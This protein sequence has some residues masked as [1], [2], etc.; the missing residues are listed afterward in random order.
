TERARRV[1]AAPQELCVAS[2][3]RHDK[4]DTCSN[5]GMT[6]RVDPCFKWNTPGRQPN[7]LQ[8]TA[9]GLWVIDQIDPNE[10]YLLSFDDCRELRRIPTRALHSSGITIDPGGNTSIASTFTYG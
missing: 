9:D 2:P 10:I 4:I 8:A 1:K 5:G 3:T 7:G 6:T